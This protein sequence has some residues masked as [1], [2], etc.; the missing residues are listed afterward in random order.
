MLFLIYE[1]VEM[2]STI[3]YIIVEGYPSTIIIMREV[4]LIIIPFK[5]GPYI[6]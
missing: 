5:L 1:I 4:A 3:I 2:F 6:L